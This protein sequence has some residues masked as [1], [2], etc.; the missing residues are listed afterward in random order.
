VFCCATCA[1]LKRLFSGFRGRAGGCGL[2]NAI[3]GVLL[4]LETIGDDSKVNDADVG[5]REHARKE[6]QHSFHT[7]ADAEARPPLPM[8]ARTRS[9]SSFLSSRAHS[10]HSSLTPQ[11]C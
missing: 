5:R 2:P 10:S 4:L 9:L 1:A 7:D 8:R 3:T 6:K 11:L